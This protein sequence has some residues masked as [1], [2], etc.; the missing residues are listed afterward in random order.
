MLNNVHGLLFTQSNIYNLRELTEPRCLSSIP[1]GGRFRMIDFMLS[2]LVNAGV[3]DVGVL[4][5]AKY[6]SLLDHLGS[7]KDW[8]LARHSGG[9]HLLPPYSLSNGENPRV[10]RGHMDTLSEIM[11]YLQD[12]RQE[13]VLIADG[14]IALN[15]DLEDVFQ[16]H[17]DNH[18]DMTLVCSPRYTGDPPAT[19]YF[20]VGDDQTITDVIQC[21]SQPA[22]VEY[23]NIFLL[24]KELLLRLV[25]ECATH[26]LYSFR[27]DL[28]PK[29]HHHLKLSA[30]AYDGFVTRC[31]SVAS[32]YDSSMA[33]L[34]PEVR[35]D[36]FCPERPIRTR[37]RNEPSSYY[38]PGSVCR[39][40]LV[41]DGCIIEGTVENSII[42]HNAR[43]GKGA[44][45]RD[46]IL[47]QN[48]VIGT[49]AQLRYVITDK[50]VTIGAGAVLNGAAHHPFV[51]AKGSTV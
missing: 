2:N 8:D 42:F 37:D 48:T 45:I 31:T 44:V 6:K 49:D 1:F 38:A 25:S 51:L 26:R 27:N 17:M 39:N 10:F 11:P 19:V 28:L 33:L 22:G 41:A 47:F 30:Y 9:L 34:Q 7:G 50:D 40:S 20:Q 32:Y 36:L 46:S 13:Y 4:L 43:V 12:I 5:L 16:Q 24:S 15:L 14:D 35:R 21:P 23:L 29:L 3:S 18:A